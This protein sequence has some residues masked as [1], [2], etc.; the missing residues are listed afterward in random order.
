MGYPPAVAA[1]GYAAADRLLRFKAWTQRASWR[2]TG[3]QAVLR[4]ERRRS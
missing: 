3:F 2:R 1:S 4:T